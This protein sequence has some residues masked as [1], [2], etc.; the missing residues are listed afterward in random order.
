MCIGEL[1]GNS[2]RNLKER[3]NTSRR[4]WQD[5]ATFGFIVEQLTTP[6]IQASNNQNN[7]ESLRAITVSCQYLQVFY[8]F[9]H[10]PVNSTSVNIIKYGFTTIRAEKEIVKR[11]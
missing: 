8:C 3:L 9:V 2:R 7:D 5:G 4:L 1:R 6:A 11:A 10:S